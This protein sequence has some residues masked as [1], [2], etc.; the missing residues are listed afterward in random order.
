MESIRFFL[1]S[2]MMV[3]LLLGTSRVFGQGSDR[4]APLLKGMGDHHHWISTDSPQAQRF[5]DQGL[6]LAYG[7]N[8]AESARSFREAIRLDPDCAMCYWG[9]AFVLGPNINAPMDKEA[10]P[11]A[12]EALQ[13]ALKFSGNASESEQAYIQALAKRYSPEPVEDR[14]TLDLTYAKAMGQVAEQYP[15]DM[16]AATLYA[17]AL[18]DTTPWNYWT[19]EGQP[20]PETK[21]IL[22]TLERVLKH[23]PNHPQA[24]HLYIHAV[25]ASPHPEWGESAADRLRDLVPGAGHLVHMPSHIYIN[26]GRYHDGTLAN[27]N[28]LAADLDYLTQ[29]HQQG[30]YPLGYVPH[31]PHFG[32]ATAAMEGN[33]K[34]ATEMARQTSALVDQN[35]M[36]K[37]GLGTLQHFYS[38]PLYNQVRFGQWQ[39]ILSMPAPAKDL[40]YP[41]GV[42]HYARGMAFTRQGRLAEAEK[43]LKAVQAIAA[44]PAL[45]TV[46]IWDI[47]STARLIK[48]A[49]EVLSGE[50]AAQQG[51]YEAAIA[52]LK[53]AVNLEDQ[54]TYTEPAD[55]SYPVRQSLGA[56]LLASDR[57]QSAEEVYRQ[58]LDRYPRNGWALFGLRQS[59]QAQGKPNAAKTVQ[60]SFDKAWQNADVTLTASRF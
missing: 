59:L 18:M 2:L 28:A 58:D 60:R 36:R 43:E 14:S 54:L 29:C 41:T 56:I 49:A 39:Q 44:D 4:T 12:W 23:S 21:I 45:E 53:T 15:D 46:T 9:V 33:Q 30:L 24:G 8:H 22:S 10:E 52:H 51:E 5:F 57:P 37:P 19:A 13:Q 31:N 34:V 11:K 7:F 32:W 50:L 47:N 1:L 20:K 55:W 40:I 26:I 25:E 6:T 38:I 17:E 35:M 42:W 48:I 16:D 27:Q 3:L